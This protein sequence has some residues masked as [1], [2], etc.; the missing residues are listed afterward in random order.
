MPGFCWLLLIAG[1]KFLGA[2]IFE[3]IFICLNSLKKV[4]K[5]M[6]L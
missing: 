5:I 4:L 1:E 2:K 6:V 3:N